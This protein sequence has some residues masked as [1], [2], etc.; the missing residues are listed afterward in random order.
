NEN[1]WL[2]NPAA[3]LLIPGLLHL[4]KRGACT[5]RFTLW[6]AA[7]LSLLAVFALASKLLPWFPQHNLPWILF[8]LPAW[9]GLLCGLWLMR[10]PRLVNDTRANPA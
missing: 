1:L 2:F 8:G 10:E 3:W 9:L 6:L 7:L 5:S 4:R